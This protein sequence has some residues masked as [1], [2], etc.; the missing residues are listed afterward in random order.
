MRAKR[1]REIYRENRKRE[2]TKD[3]K[4]EI[5]KRETERKKGER[6]RTK[7]RET[8]VQDRK[9]ITKERQ[10][11]RE[12]EREREREKKERERE[13]EKKERERREKLRQDESK[14]MVALA[15]LC[16]RFAKLQ[17]PQTRRGRSHDQTFPQAFP[18][19]LSSN[20][21]RP[22]QG[23]SRS[24]RPSVFKRIQDCH[25]PAFKP[26]QAPAICF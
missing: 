26:L 14:E 4:R 20:F 2:R 17:R 13:R 1:R 8:D 15:C 7:E 21:R 11:E 9:N 24:Y 6:K 12:T 23:N 18:R 25:L 5:K 10:R 3:R 16:L 22:F 19:Q